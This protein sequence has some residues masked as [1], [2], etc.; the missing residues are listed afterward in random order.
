MRWM[1]LSLAVVL[2]ALSLLT[3]IKAWHTTVWRLAIIAGEYGHYLG[4][5]ALALVCVIVAY[6]FVM[7]GDDQPYWRPAGIGVVM[8]LAA[9]GFFLSP[10]AFALRIGQHL[11]TKL[12]AAF[13]QKPD[14]GRAMDLQRMWIPVPGVSEVPVTTHVFTPS[15]WAEPL[16]LDFYAAAE[17]NAP[18]V[19]MVHGGGWDSGDRMQIAHFNHW[20]A[21][22][23]YHVAAISYRLAPE[24]PWPAQR[25]DTLQAI[26]WLKAHAVELQLDPQR[27]VL[28]GRSA[29][30]QIAAAVAYGEP[31]PGVRGFIGLYGVYDMNFVWSVSRPDD[32]LNSTN[33]MNQYLGGAPTPANQADYDSASAQGLV[34]TGQTP[35]TLL[36][37]G[38][39]DTLCWVKH[40]QRLA[41][42][43][44]D[45]S[46]PHAFIELPWAVHAFDFNL[47]GPGGQL[48]TYAV[49]AFLAAVCD[50]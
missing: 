39:I 23:G 48:T 36:I 12:E 11:P 24:Y 19:V 15:D 38:T 32:V 35:P 6:G 33:L 34:R 31:D 17:T 37:H 41:D 7:V 49:K 3:L 4:L 45:K 43:L 30:A 14:S 29:G 28:M 40:S 9:A 10:A 8:A 2:L 1:F 20:L 46:I 27:M 18:V 21:G 47:T 26:T 13:G 50:E 42:E 16:K 22:Q 5:V 44:R 25:A